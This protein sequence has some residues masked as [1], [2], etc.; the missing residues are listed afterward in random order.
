MQNIPNNDSDKKSKIL[1][2]DDESRNIRLLEQICK[3]LGYHAVTADSGQEAIDKSITEMPDLI[4]MD[5]MMP[6][7]DG[8]EAT[9]IIK[10]N[11][12]T[13]HIPVIILTA[14][15]EKKDRIK[16]IAQGANDFLSKPFDV[17]E[18]SLRIKN[19]L[20]IKEYHDFIKDHN[21][22]LE[23][24]VKKRTEE[25]NKAYEKLDATYH[26]VQKSYI[27]TIQRLNMAAEY[28]DE[29]TGSHIRRTSL[30]TKELATSLG[31]DSDFI[32]NIYYASPMHDIGKVG[33]PDGILMKSGSLTPEE[34]TVMKSHTTIGAK[35][36]RGSESPLLKMAEE[37]A[38]SHHERW[39]GNGYP[40]GLKGEEIPLSGRITNIVDQYDALRSKRP[41]KINLHHDTVL[42]II[43]EGDGRTAPIDFDPAI[44]E[45][46]KK[47]A[48]K[49]D[50]IF[51]TENEAD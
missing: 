36:L 6:G 40:G 8:F 18:L 31:M 26:T 20:Q 17:E 41:Y 9:G 25:L 24:E 3:N 30:Y 45:A 22:L 51:N 12:A 11:E 23:S 28:K 10:S 13:G 46:F 27:E 5:V 21:I 14:L 44:M 47:S 19:N 43:T 34:W 33:I 15:G 37:I 38:L 39:N 32:E 2:V 50:E 29:D 1:L 42:K 16:G 48:K 7:M 49:F 4:L 35:I